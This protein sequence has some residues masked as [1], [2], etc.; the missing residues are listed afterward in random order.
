MRDEN[1]FMF[2]NLAVFSEIKE[3]ITL[4]A[5]ELLRTV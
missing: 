1:E 4:K 5:V 3:R 2:F